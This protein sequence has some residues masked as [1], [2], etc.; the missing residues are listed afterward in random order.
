[1]P[2]PEYV[3]TWLT[4]FDESSEP[5]DCSMIS[6]I[7]YSRLAE[8]QTPAV[9]V[10]SIF[11][12]LAPLEFHIRPRGGSPWDTYFA[13]KHEGTNPAGRDS[14][15][16]DLADLDC[17]SVDEWA[18]L[19]DRF[20]NPALK[21]RFAD[22]VWELSKRLAPV[23]RDRYRFA[24]MAAESY[25][26]AAQ[27]GRYGSPVLQLEPMARAV[28]LALSINSEDLTR[29]SVEYSLDFATAVDPSHLGL[30][31]APFDK[32]LSL[33]RLPKAYQ[34]RIL[35]QFESRFEESVRRQELH[36][37]TM[38]GQALAQYHYVRQNY[39]RAK[40]VTRAYGEL[41]LELT[42]TMTATIAV[43]HISDVLEDYRRQ[44]LREDAD[45][46]RL[47][48][49]KRGKGVADEMKRV[50]IP[51]KIDSENVERFTREVLDVDDPY[52]A[53]FRVAYS[54]LPNVDR[55]RDQLA[56]RAEGFLM[57]HLIPT[58]ITGDNGLPVALVNTYDDDQHGNL[59][60]ETT[61]AMNFDSVYL[62]NSLDEWKK[63][64]GLEGIQETPDLY[65][66]PLIVEDRIPFFRDGL[67]AYE[68]SDYLK[69]IH[70]LIPQVENCLRRLL[71]LLNLSPT[72]SSDEGDGTY[73]LKNMYDCLNEK[74]VR[75]ALEDK[76]WYFLKALYVDNRGLNLRNVM[77]HG[78]AEYEAFNKLNAALVVQSVVLLS[79][80]RPSAV[81]LAEEETEQAGDEAPEVL[82]SSDQKSGKG[83][84]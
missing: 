3:Q 2:L 6:L 68:A 67:A 81:T 12:V 51:I 5:V 61:R 41:K 78:I 42:T 44:G 52:V 34:E 83:V 8:R 19:A 58:C 69:A 79:I 40:K 75:E 22:A 33:G 73:E 53:L 63:K 30:W 1:M 26:K 65:D 38:A 82:A 48:L 80:V 14:D 24:V 56:A 45:R 47:L 50:W 54:T 17:A 39:D 32:I 7:L 46:V 4:G 23:R 11:R 70:V 36:S 57:R 59:V 16:P 77:S 18:A 43:H 60:M 62:L 20:T 31:M 55:I 84:S 21:A 28:S 13:P 15:Y 9:E 27:E 10:K 25:L 37:S 74:G 29:R 66:S 72:K 64:F 35:K 76:L 71:E 49:E